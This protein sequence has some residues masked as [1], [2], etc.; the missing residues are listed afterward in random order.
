MF[1]T[2]MYRSTEYTAQ[3]IRRKLANFFSSDLL[4][5]ASDHGSY[6][7]PAS[8]A[9]RVSMETPSRPLIG[10]WLHSFAPIV[11]CQ[12]YGPSRPSFSLYCVAR[13]RSGTPRGV[14]HDS[15]LCSSIRI[16][17]SDDYYLTYTM[18]GSK[19]TRILSSWACGRQ[20]QTVLCDTFKCKISHEFAHVVGGY[21][22]DPRILVNLRDGILGEGIPD[23]LVETTPGTPLGG[24]LWK[25]SISLFCSSSPL[26]LDPSPVRLELGRP[27][28]HLIPTLDLT[29]LSINKSLL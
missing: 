7:Q 21:R 17:R 4:G 14:T 22:S 15:R 28:C 18:H 1:D 20:Y 12:L 6:R 26:K 5:T 25:I 13:L 23:F 29:R 19:T 9:V 16:G 8:P 3:G 10:A 27:L 24:I 2:T 11:R